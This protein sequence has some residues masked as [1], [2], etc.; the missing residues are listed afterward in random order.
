MNYPVWDIPFLGNGL[1]V[2]IIAIIHILISHLAI[3][4]GAFLFIAEIWS[5]R[6]PD[7]GRI[8]DWLH[9]YATY[10]LVYTTVFGAV[11][12]VGIWFSIQLANAEATSLLIHQY[13]FA[14]A[15]EWVMFLG[16][17]TTLYFYYYG[18][19]KN[20]RSLQVFL[21]GAYFVIAWMSL[22]IING[23]LSFML[24]PG[25]WTLA[26]HDIVA[27]FFNPGYWPSL[28]IRTLTMF[29]IGGLFG[30]IIATRITGDDDLKARIIK[31]SARW[32]IPAAIIV[33]FL[34]FWYWSTLPANTVALVKG[35]AVGLA[36]GK[37]EV[38]TR[39]FWLALGSGFL[40]ITGTIFILIRPQ[41]ASTAGAIALFLIAQTGI[42][43]AEFFREMARK[44]YVIYDNLYSNQLWKDKTGDETYMKSSYLDNTKWHPE[45]EPLS[46]EHGEYVFRL[47]CASCHTRDGYR[48]LV[49]R[50]VD[51]TGEFSYKWLLTM[52][53]QGVMPPF[54][55]NDEDRAA[56][57][58]YLLSLHDKT[59]NAADLLKSEQPV[60]PDST[61][62]A[63][64]TTATA[65][66]RP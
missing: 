12:G 34:M 47:Q 9:K 45:I 54:Q 15:I 37:L 16:E 58:A 48:S 3:G 17:L 26:N 50:T 41:A 1:V 52:D 25:G 46:L 8:R 10:F 42:L 49:S 43:G 30:I 35:G 24:T 18:W 39:Y 33:P 57:S 65:E 11:T 63:V 36:G 22:F 19:R 56:L 66:V 55:G 29:L 60:Q 59:I 38:I 61:A 53:Q 27:G 2:A 40:I 32:I 51:W 5:N 7:G 14:W 21:A 28:F 13:V 20:S 31:F 62:Q 64:D 4:G 44:P 23:I 6:Q